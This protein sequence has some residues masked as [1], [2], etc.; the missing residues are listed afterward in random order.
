MGGGWVVLGRLGWAVAGMVCAG[1][2]CVLFEVGCVLLV[3]LVA[4]FEGFGWG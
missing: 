4:G 3:G 2:T 1:M